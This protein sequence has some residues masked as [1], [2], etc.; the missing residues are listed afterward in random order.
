MPSRLVMRKSEVQSDGS[1]TSAT[2]TCKEVDP[3]KRLIIITTQE[4]IAAD[5]PTQIELT[6]ITNPRSVQPT[7]VIRI[8]TFDADGISEIDSGF[9]IG[10]TMIDLAKI[11]G[12]SVRPSSTINGELNTYTFTLST[13]VNFEKGDVL[14]Y[15]MPAQVGLPTTVN[16]INI[17]P[18]P[19][20]V[21]GK[22]V[23]DKLKVVISGQTIYVTFL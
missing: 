12:F 6:G 4:I 3:V 17:R 10:T 7:D 15:T 9:N 1:C 8:V 13:I 2:L 11:T 5:T 16:E 21:D 18:L 23:T 19:R 22:K 14:Q 20:T